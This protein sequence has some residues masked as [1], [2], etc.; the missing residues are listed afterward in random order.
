MVR[1]CL[2]SHWF[3]GSRH[4]IRDI[5]ELPLMIHGAC[6]DL[7]DLTQREGLFVTTIIDLSG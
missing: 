5:D 3:S 6:N 1:A 7:N 4:G 2:Q